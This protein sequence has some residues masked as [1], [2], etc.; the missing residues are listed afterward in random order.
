MIGA[1]VSVL[2]KHP[3]IRKPREKPQRLLGA[4]SSGAKPYPSP[5]GEPAA[6]SQYNKVLGTPGALSPELPEISI[7]LLPAL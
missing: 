1:T 3:H 2:C 7:L 6:T 5:S 4:C